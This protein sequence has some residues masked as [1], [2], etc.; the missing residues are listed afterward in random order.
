[1][2][3]RATFEL[4]EVAVEGLR[5]LIHRFPLGHARTRGD[6]SNLI[7]VD[8]ALVVYAP[9]QAR[10]LLSSD[11]FLQCDDVAERIEMPPELLRTRLHYA[12]LNAERIVILGHRNF[13]SVASTVP[14]PPR[15]CDIPPSALPV[16][17]H[18]EGSILVVHTDEEMWSVV[19]P[20]LADSFPQEEFTEFDEH[21]VFEGRWK[22]ALHIGAATRTEPGARLVDAWAGGVP[23]VQ[24]L[25]PGQ[26]QAQTDSYSP[27]S[28]SPPKTGLQA[29]SISEL[30]LLLEDLIGDEFMTRALAQSASRQD[31]GR[32]KWQ[33]VLDE[34]L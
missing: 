13:V 26:E 21:D 17:N 25:Q 24:F 22:I 4:E 2:H 34:L 33:D 29:H 30:L 28:V 8:A 23:V 31:I 7:A 11:P 15:L 14:T 16:A 12:L 27:T 20:R 32:G 10:L 9:Y 3:N 19:R 6:D 18:K 5:S 1:L